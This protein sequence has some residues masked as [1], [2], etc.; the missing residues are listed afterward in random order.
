[1]R[2][3]IFMSLKGEIK[4]TIVYGGSFNPPTKAHEEI[5]QLLDH[6]FHPENILLIPVGDYYSWK[7]TLIPYVY[8]KEMLK[9]IIYSSHVKIMDIENT[10]DF[11]G[12]YQTLRDLSHTYNDLYFVIGTDHVETM[13]LWKDYEKLLK[14]FSFIVIK[15]KDFHP[16]LEIFMKYQTKVQLIDFDSSISSSKIRANIHLHQNDLNASVYKYILENNLYQE[17]SK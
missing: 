11:K 6:Q 15:R 1:M 13:H 12:T 9:R 2:D 5:I 3:I 8:R 10:N 14:E 4:M 16:N 17:V 7:N